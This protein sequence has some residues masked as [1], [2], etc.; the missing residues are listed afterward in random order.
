M[1]TDAL[2]SLVS[3][4][5]PISLANL[6]TGAAV[7]SQVIDLLGSGVGTAPQNIIGTRTVFGQT[8]GVDWLKPAI[9]LHVGTAF[10]TSSSCTLTVQFQ[11]SVDSGVSGTPPYS[12]N[13][14]ITYS[15]VPGLTAAQLIAQR[16]IRVDF[17]PNFPFETLP[18]FLQLNFQTLSGASFT[19]GTIAN[20]VVTLVR[21]DYGEKYAAKNYTVA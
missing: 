7:A 20:A 16:S 9:M 5:S 12:P 18:R 14:W 3:P 19:A 2:L 4:G 17:Q 11:G 1:I 10:T 15:E 13:A 8:V 21:D 6:A